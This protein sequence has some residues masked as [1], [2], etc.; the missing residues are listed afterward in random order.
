MTP[1]W[2]I[3]KKAQADH[4]FSGEGARLFGGRWNH[5]GTAVVYTADTL[6]LAALEYF[7]HLGPAMAG[8]ELVFF[9]AEI[10]KRMV[11]QDLAPETLPAGW[12]SEPPLAV[13]RHLG[14][15]WAAGNTTA[16]LRV[17]SALIPS[18]FNFI[19]NPGHPDFSRIKVLGPD[20]F[21]FDSRMWK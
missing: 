12:R 7:V 16:V 14:S 8:V 5:R 9:K 1:V 10:P 11:I 2:R 15:D 19:L 13:T 18:Q 20:P 21:R 4:A 6:S 17:P 3:V